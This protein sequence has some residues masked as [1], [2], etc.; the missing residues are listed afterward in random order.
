MTSH[1][2]LK[3]LHASLCFF[4]VNSHTAGWFPFRRQ[5]H[6]EEPNHQQPPEIQPN[7]QN[8][9]Q[10]MDQVGTFSVRFSFPLSLIF[11]LQYCDASVECLQILD[12]SLINSTVSFSLSEFCLFFYF[13]SFTINLIDPHHSLVCDGLIPNHS[14]MISDLQTWEG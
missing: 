3:N 11:F 4:F 7:Q 5:A 9:N 8:E 10:N 13:S 6:V 1:I 14:K 12:L 2:F